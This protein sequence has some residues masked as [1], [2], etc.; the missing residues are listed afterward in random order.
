MRAEATF[1]GEKYVST[2]G[3]MI[4]SFGPHAGAVTPMEPQRDAV[5]AL[6]YAVNGRLAEAQAVLADRRREVLAHWRDSMAEVASCR[7]VSLK[8]GGIGMPMYM[9]WD[10]Q[11]VPPTSAEL[12]AAWQDEIRFCIDRFGPSRCL[13]ESNFPVDKRGCSYVVLWNAFKR[14]ATDYSPSEKR[15]L[16][17]NSA[18]RA[19]RLP[20]VS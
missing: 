7:N 16:F 6:L 5:V 18:A 10:R 1:V 12:A 8:L 19:Y 3:A 20:P 14:I 15:D 4:L 13:F 9:R 17:H 11:A 2:L